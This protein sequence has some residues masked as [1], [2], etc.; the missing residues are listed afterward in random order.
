MK[1]CNLCY[2]VLEKRTNEKFVNFK[3]RIFCNRICSNAFRFQDITNQRF[4]KLIAIKFIKKNIKKNKRKYFWLF[5]CDC[6][7]EKIIN[8]HNVK[9]NGTKSCGCLQKEIAKKIGSNYFIHKM[10][11]NRF[12]KI[13]IGIKTRCNNIKAEKYLIYG[14]RGI[15][16]LWTSFEEFRDD[17]YECYLEHCNKFGEKNTTIDRIDNN[18]N[19]CLENCRWA[20]QKEQANNRRKINCS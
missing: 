20:T 1:T 17:M 18:G 15:K 8:S 6:G 9:N 11:K 10:S 13:F 2:K 7:N 16:C 14:G 12:Y 5:K 19:Y 3:K 4:G